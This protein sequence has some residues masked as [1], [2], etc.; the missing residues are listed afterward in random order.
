MPPRKIIPAIAIDPLAKALEA[1]HKAATQDGVFVIKDM[2]EITVYDLA[3][4]DYQFDIEWSEEF[5]DYQVV[6]P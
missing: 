2:F 1:L 3:G 6:L 4:G 5:E